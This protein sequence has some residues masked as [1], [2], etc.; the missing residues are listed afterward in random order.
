[1]SLSTWVSSAGQNS[2]N[3]I[4]AWCLQ[5]LHCCPWC[6]Q[7]LRAMAPNL[8]L[9]TSELSSQSK[10]VA[11]FCSSLSPMGFLE[12]SKAK[13]Q[14]LPTSLAQGEDTG[15]Y[16]AIGYWRGKRVWIWSWRSIFLCSL[17][18]G[19]AVRKGVLSCFILMA[20]FSLHWQLLFQLLQ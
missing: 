3:I 13:V 8:L 4:P 9:Q 14:L 11:N 16:G 10:T 12:R 18:H 5:S 20:F 7:H 2:Q 19:I 6:L 1:M 15:D 17:I